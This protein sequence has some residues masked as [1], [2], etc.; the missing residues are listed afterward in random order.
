VRRLIVIGV[1]GGM[2]SLAERFMRAGR[3]P[4]LARLCARGVFAEALPSIPVDTPTNWTTI[5]T[6]A[7][8]ATHGVYSFTSHTAGEPLD[9]GRQ[10]PTRN[11]SSS[12]SR[13]AF[14]WNALERAGWRCAVVNYPTGWPSTL[15]R[16][17]VV[18]GVTPGGEPW[19]LARPA[20][21]AAG[22]P[23]V[24]PTTLPAIKFSWRPLVLAEAR[25]WRGAERLGFRPLEAEIQLGPDGA[26]QT[27]H[28][29]IAAAS[30]RGY[31]R[32]VVSD[33]RDAAAPLATLE[34]GEWSPWITRTFDGAPG[35]LRMKLAALSADAR[36]V[37][38][39]VS[40][41]VRAEGW[42][43]PAGLERGI[44][45]RAGP[46]VE[47]LE[48]PYVPFDVHTRPYG[49]VNVSSSFMLEHARLQAAWMV[50]L[51]AHLREAPGWDALILHYHYLDA[52][53]HTYL[54]YLYDRFPASTPQIAAEAW[55]LY[56][57]SYAVVDDLIGGL[58]GG[59]EEALVVVTSDHAGLPCW[60]HVAIAPALARA[61]LLAY[62]WDRDTGVYRADL[63]RSQAVPY[64]DPQHIWI[65]LAGREPGGTVPPD[66][67]EAARD[68]VIEALLAIRDPETGAAPVRLA[69]RREDLGVVGK[70]ADR[71]GDVLFFLRPG[72]TTWDGT[73]Q[74]LRFGTMTPERLAA[75]VVTPSLEVVGH[76]TPHLPTAR[77]G[78]FTN[79]AF[80]VFSGP[81]VRG[82]GR[83]DA[84]IRLV[85][86]A[87]TIARLLG[88]AP[89]SHAQGAAVPDIAGDP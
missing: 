31:D 5:M 84:A 23:R 39:Y 73:L 10:P 41:V 42:T 61:G 55:D 59:D 67:Y 58:V 60:R 65:N 29:A 43:A 19:R 89:P 68:A 24:I 80:T 4:H 14:L 45:D 38:L 15:E 17:V 56:A 35:V 64:L 27:F 48:C 33:G 62:A 6:G 28:L 47:G 76:H 44:I 34:P 88:V 57:E 3:M 74:S 66:R 13:A 22:T 21:F 32:V 37:E 26:A 25:G 8:P 7:E 77:L 85:D 46:Y 40:D 12:F 36:Q 9:E 53:N 49:P 79:S 2:L 81:G 1:D 51:A 20:V 75:P 83:R 63:T 69:V 18:G 16:G 87:P 72:Y 82:G 86:V 30:G 52:L 70:S 50:E 71:A 11:K 78:E 54:G